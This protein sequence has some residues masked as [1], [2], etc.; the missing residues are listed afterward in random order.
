LLVRAKRYDVAVNMSSDKAY[1]FF[2]LSHTNKP[3][4]QTPSPDLKMAGAKQSYDAYDDEADFDDEYFL[5][6]Y[7]PLSN[8]PTPPPSCRDSIVSLS[9]KSINEQDELL[10]SALLGMSQNSVELTVDIRT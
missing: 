7:Q 5:R 4:L 3:G 9:T 6:T 8:L 2:G 10:E 1:C